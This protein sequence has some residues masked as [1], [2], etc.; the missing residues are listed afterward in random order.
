MRAFRNL[1]AGIFIKDSHSIA[2]ED[3]IV[4]DNPTGIDIHRAH[5]IL[6]HN[7]SFVGMSETYHQQ[8]VAQP[9]LPSVCP[10]NKIIGLQLHLNGQNDEMWG[11]TIEGAKFRRFDVG[12]NQQTVIG[13]DQ[14]V[15]V[16]T[17]I[18]TLWLSRCTI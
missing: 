13:V 18:P 15:S 9:T 12:C 1:A 16:L 14:I 8:R 11:D 7:V 3:S 6:I 4:S 5:D 17:T 10:G 2:V